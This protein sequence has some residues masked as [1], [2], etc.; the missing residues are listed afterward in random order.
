MTI[1]R[2]T[3]RFDSISDGAHSILVHSV[4]DINEKD[5]AKKLIEETR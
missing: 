5:P 1:T 4:Q 3:G 2:K